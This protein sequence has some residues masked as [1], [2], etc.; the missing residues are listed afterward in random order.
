MAG[1]GLR[2]PCTCKCAGRMLRTLFAA[3]LHPK[4]SG[5]AADRARGAA[6][7][8]TLGNSSSCVSDRGRC[9]K[10]V[11]VC[12]SGWEGPGCECP[13]SNDTC[14]DS[15]G[16]GPALPARGTTGPGRAAANFPDARGSGL[17]GAGTLLTPRA[18]ACLRLLSD[19][20]CH[21]LF[22][23]AFA[24]TMGGANAADAS[25]TRLRCTPAPPAKSATPW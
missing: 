8:W 11:C 24:I 1:D 21:L 12:E 4:E 13:T 7:H 3:P 18:A 6:Q 20:D 19:A 16:V 23:R 22:P 10:G 15:R 5:R 14:I 17:L 25:V 2:G 9:S